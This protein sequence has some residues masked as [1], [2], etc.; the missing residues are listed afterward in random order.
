M[1]DEF[2]VM[3]TEMVFLVFPPKI[4]NHLPDH[5]YVILQSFGQPPPAPP[6]NC[7]YICCIAK[8]DLKVKIVSVLST[9]QA[10]PHLIYR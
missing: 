8:Y 10:T 2:F 7:R 3:S 5:P 1:I 6:S 9:G 4:P